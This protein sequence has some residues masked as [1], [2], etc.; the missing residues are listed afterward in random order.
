MDKTCSDARAALEGV[1]RDGMTILAGGFVAGLIFGGNWDSRDFYVWDHEGKL[2]RKVPNSTGNS[3]QD[4]KFHGGKLVGSG[5]LADGQAVIDWLE[6]PDFR[7]VRRLTAGKTD[8]G[9]PM[10][11]E[12]M[13]LWGDEIWFLPEDG[14]SRLF[15]FDLPPSF[16]KF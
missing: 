13:T 5:T 11:R 7:P 12:G 15:Q 14:A 16:K 2:L 6:L 10:T 9:A 8:T 3:F 4:L 1:V